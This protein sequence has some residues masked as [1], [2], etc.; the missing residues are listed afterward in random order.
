M[1]A[2]LLTI[3]QGASASTIISTLEIFGQHNAYV[4]F[5]GGLLIVR[6]IFNDQIYLLLNKLIYSIYQNKIKDSLAS[7]LQTVSSAQIFDDRGRA[8]KNYTTDI[9]IYIGGFLAPIVQLSID[10]MVITGLIIY[11]SSLFPIDLHIISGLLVSFTLLLIL[12]RILSNTANTEGRARND[13]DG[14]K[15]EILSELSGT[16]RSLIDLSA[17]NF[18]IKHLDKLNSKYASASIKIAKNINLTKLTIETYVGLMLVVTCAIMGNSVAY[19]PASAAV[20]VA[21]FLRIVPTINRSAQA[22]MAIQASRGALESLMN[23]NE[24]PRLRANYMLSETAETLEIEKC[25]VYSKEQEILSLRNI[26]I[27]KNKI[28]V[29]TAPSGTGKSVLLKSLH[30]ELRQSS[31]K[32]AYLPQNYNL[33]ATSVLQNIYLN[34]GKANKREAIL[35]LQ[36][37]GFSKDAAEKMLIDDKN[38]QTLSGGESQRLFLARYLVRD[39][40]FLFM[41]EITSAL[42]KNTEDHIFSILNTLSSNC[43]IVIN[44]HTQKIQEPNINYI[45]LIEHLT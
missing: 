39:F 9:N 28:T 20:A 12:L 2:D 4:Y 14:H 42:D 26:S 41:D 37:V 36:K 40:D 45:N 5:L 24:T 35:L 3:L 19:S 18:Y 22:I 21:I 1:I 23:N 7:R 11:A 16:W 10:A 31:Y 32:V 13:V 6:L 27:I 17:Q 33:L 29:I 43:T 44:S 25:N 34:D 15:A 30:Q 8:V 38:V